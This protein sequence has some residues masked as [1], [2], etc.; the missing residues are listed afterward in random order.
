[1][2]AAAKDWAWAQNVRGGE[3]LLLI[4]LAERADR[5]GVTF[6]GRA[7]AVLMTGLSAASVTSNMNKLREK[8]LVATFDR[9]RANGSRT[10][11]WT[12]L[13]PQ[14]NRGRMEDYPLEDIPV[15]VLL[16]ARSSQVSLPNDSLRKDSVGGQVKKLGGPEPT[17]EPTDVERGAGVRADGLKFDGKKL[18][19]ARWD[20][21]QRVLAEFNRQSGQKVRPVTSAGLLSEGSKRIYGRLGVYPDLTFD[22]LADIIRRTAA[23]HWWGS[24]DVSIGVVFGEKVFEDNITRKGA[25]TAN[26]RLSEKE[27]RLR[28]SRAR[29]KAAYEREQARERV[30]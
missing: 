3:K 24:G 2:S 4:A 10:S 16:A 30:A 21:C 17:E 11:D 18:N 8:K 13:A 1:M 12:V 29:A 28:D 5:Y 6:I 14:Q 26:G 20:L 9:R 19:P 25:R 15:E 7:A 22:E 27:Q 23:S